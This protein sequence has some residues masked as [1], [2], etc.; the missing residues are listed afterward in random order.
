MAA[1]VG[2]RWRGWAGARERRRAGLGRAPVRGAGTGDGGGLVAA[3]AAAGE[4]AGQ[5]LLA[6]GELGG[7]GAFPAR[8]VAGAAAAYV[9]IPFCQRRCH[10]C[11]FP[12]SVVGS[13]GAAV[14][15]A[16]EA[17]EEYVSLVLREF[18]AMEVN[19]GAAAPPP[20]RTVFFGGGTPSLL[21]PD[22][23]EALLTGL[24]A[25]FGLDPRAEVSLE[26]DPGTFNREG[27]G[28]LRAAGV[29]RL[30][31]GVQSFNEG[32]LE[33]CGRAHS[34][35]DALEA[36]DAVH[37][38]GFASWSL[39]LMS[40]LP[41]QKLDTW[42]R[43][44]EQAL[45]AGSDHLSVYDLQVEAGTPFAR[46]YEPGARPLP[47][48]SEAA[49]M[50][51]LASRTLRGAGFEHY[52]VSSYARP[53]HRCEHNQVY[54]SGETFWGFGLGAASFLGGRRVTRPRKMRAYE[55]WVPQLEARPMAEE[56]GPHTEDQAQALALD[57]LLDF[58]MLQLRLSD[59]LALADV[60]ERMGGAGRGARA[61]EGV[62]EAVRPH[63]L[64]GTALVE[65]EGP[66]RRIR[67]ADPDGFL[68]SNDVIS[69]VFAALD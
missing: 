38:V 42:G 31:L 17:M 7:G 2:G 13:R 25:A 39:D 49:E 16:R 1:R 26:A 11:D 37:A 41:N 24:D 54:W 61:A 55:A 43:T 18:K 10:Y 15:A 21:P 6:N 9:H 35:R 14:P 50:Y 69:D 48:E 58:V 46:W 67:L 64:A 36:V 4:A 27:L 8:V 34:L 45:D 44:L 62:L 60:A 59:G 33:A 28:A 30:S 3:T 57:A 22:L 65:G 19:S 20:L 47:L 32:E 40:G 63:V 12:I 5:G 52:E 68:V 66:G 53:G 56:P 23:L 51:R 29:T